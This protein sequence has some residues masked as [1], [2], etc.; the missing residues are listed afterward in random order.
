MTVRALTVAVIVA[1]S[2]AATG[3][4]AAARAHSAAAHPQSSTPGA[5]STTARAQSTPDAKPAATG[6]I[7]GR[8]VGSDTG[9]PLRRAR[10]LLRLAV[11]QAG[12]QPPIAVTTSSSTG[13]F[14]FKDVPAGQYRLEIGRAGYLDVEY[15]QRRPREPGQTIDLRDG[16]VLDR[17]E[18]AMPRV[19]VIAGRVSD[20]RGA[21]YPGLRVE[22]YEL[23]YSGGQRLS[24]LAAAATTDDRGQY[25]ISGLNPGSYYVSVVSTE[26]WMAS[27]GAS[28]GFV[29]TYYP[30]VLADAAQAIALAV[31]QQ[32]TDVS[33]SL[34]AD[35]T[36]RLSGRL[37]RATGEVLAGETI[38]LSMELSTRSRLA[39]SVRTAGE[40]TFEFRDVAPGNYRIGL[41]RQAANG[42]QENG[43][44][45]VTVRGIDVAD[46]VV[47]LTGG[48]TIGGVITTDVGTVPPFA[49]SLRINALT[50]SALGVRGFRTFPVE[51]SGAFSFEDTL[52]P[53]LIRLNGLPEGWMLRSIRNGDTEVPEGFLDVQRGRNLTDLRLVV[54]SKAGKV[55]GDVLDAEGKATS[56]ATIVL[57]PD[58]EALW[59]GGS[60]FL[61]TTR[62]DRDG[63]FTING[64]LP[65]RYRVAVREYVEDGAGEAA[66]YLRTLKSSASAF[67]LTEGG[68]QTL[69][70]KLPR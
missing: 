49:A 26:T 37:Q 35:R 63:H 14:T 43:M 28:Y 65:G 18:I 3:S 2:L 8:I 23:R 31:G 19:S 45:R 50:E 59:V 56:D 66:V 16:A 52:S 51:A 34:T 68:S 22:A 17:L 55:S 38:S 6:T 46:L 25:R 39:A 7:R 20:D 54:T 61:R 60:R 32:R 40:G 70:L 9:W 47:T 21:P 62:P 69:T 10:V 33:F 44:V 13:A 5:P 4:T 29:P 15:G 42:R 27:N 30:G 67:D 48:S 24:A 53:V 36:A 41:T 12:G 58:N 1:C 64:L 11:T 57:F